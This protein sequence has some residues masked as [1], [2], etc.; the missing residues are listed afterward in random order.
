M[1]LFG[2]IL[3]GAFIAAMGS[4]AVSQGNYP[5]AFLAAALIPLVCV[6]AIK[7]I[8]EDAVEELNKST[9]TSEDS[10]A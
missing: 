4:W 1:R 2:I 9:K 5:A 3:C 8:I 7:V 6:M 10:G